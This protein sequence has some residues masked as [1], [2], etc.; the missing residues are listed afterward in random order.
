MI[1]TLESVLKDDKLLA[2]MANNS[3]KI[4]NKNP[5][6]KIKKEIARIIKNK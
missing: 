3:K 2:S 5:L 6:D 4:E 1:E